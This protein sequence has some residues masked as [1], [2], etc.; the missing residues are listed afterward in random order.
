MRGQKPEG[1]EPAAA[2]QITRLKH[3]RGSARNSGGFYS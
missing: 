2:G 1:V 3:S